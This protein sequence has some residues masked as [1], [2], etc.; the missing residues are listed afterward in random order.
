MNNTRINELDGLR[1]IAAI[2]VVLYH[3]TTR[4]SA[5]FN[6][7]IITDHFDFKYGSYGV[8]LFFIISGFVIFM[9]IEKVKTPFEF[10]YKR[11]IRLYPTF[12]IC[13]I[14]TFLF[15]NSYGENTL[16]VTLKD[17]L[18]NFT[19]VPSLFNA[20]TVD[21]VYWSLI[22][23]M[24][25]YTIMLILIILKKTK[26]IVKYSY[27]YIAL[28]IIILYFY[29]PTSYFHYGTLFIIGINFF[30][31]W[32]RQDHWWHHLQIFFC[33]TLTINQQNH[34]PTIIT[35]ILIL[36]FYLL[37]NKRLKFLESPPL[38]FLGKI[39]YALYLVHQNIGN[40]IQLK[41]IELGFDNYMYLIITPLVISLI[42]SSGITLLLEK[43]IIDKLSKHQ[44]LIMN[45]FQ[46]FKNY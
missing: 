46:L 10:V 42:L 15:I 20:K 7:N 25:F 21:G 43:P 14:I 5:K 26:N 44:N 34:V 16:K 24:F 2:C 6:T 22:V 40:T 36:T 31:I 17:F 29:R 39:S 30:Y 38:L 13:M 41:M 18:V 45:P 8:D 4:F 11:F 27:I 35:S 19:M 33:L 9:S 32:K 12:W 3:Y 1:G 23:E 28:G 37:V